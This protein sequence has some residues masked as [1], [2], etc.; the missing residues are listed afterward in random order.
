[1]NENRIYKRMSYDRNPMNFIQ[2]TKEQVRKIDRST[3][4]KRIKKHTSL[5]KDG[6]EMRNGPQGMTC[7]LKKQICGL[8]KHRRRD[9]RIRMPLDRWSSDVWHYLINGRWL[10]IGIYR[11]SDNRNPKSLNH[12]PSGNGELFTSYPTPNNGVGIIDVT[13]EVREELS[14]QSS[15][16]WMIYL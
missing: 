12:Y 3:R 16:G 6:V 13:C 8:S 7:N 11:I 15:R 2:R 9:P 14:N 4:H 5:Q 10:I 1:M